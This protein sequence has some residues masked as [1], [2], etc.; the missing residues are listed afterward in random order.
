MRVVAGA[1]GVLGT[2][3]VAA[4]PGGEGDGLVSA[5]RS[6]RLVMLSADCATVA[7]GS[8]QGVFA[9]VHA[10]W[11]GLSAGVIEAVAGAMRRLGATTLWGALGPTIHPG[12]YPFSEGD[13]SLMV[14]R[15]GD[16]I[17]FRSSSGRPALDLP[18]TVR[19]AFGQAGILW[20]EGIDACTSCSEEYF[21][22]RAHGDVGRQ[23]LVVWSVAPE[24]REHDR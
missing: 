12:C 15:Y 3:G 22:H 13:L 17:R 24:H 5:S 4:Q 11:R 18:G 6:A 10:G 23:A 9:A 14:T 20:V 2:T 1:E 21:S 19:A 7:L 8:E 16:G